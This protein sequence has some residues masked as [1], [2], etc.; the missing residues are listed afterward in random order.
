LSERRR[1]DR[2]LLILGLKIAV[3]FAAVLLVFRQDLAI[4]AADALQNESTSY[5]LAIP[6]LFA[7]LVYRKRR[8]LRT[9]IPLESQGQPK[10][11]RYSGTMAGVLLSST[12]ILLYWYGSHT[13]TPLEYHMLTLPVF[14][15]GLTLIL[16]NTHT[17]RQLAFAL[18]FLVLLTPPPSEILSNVGSTLS[19]ISSEVDRKSVV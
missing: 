17:V 15:A 9:V 13:F 6:F 16:F 4:V 5:I 1:P 3:I 12:A 10:I 8:M 18:A 7:Y 2:G 11:M 14:A 19:V